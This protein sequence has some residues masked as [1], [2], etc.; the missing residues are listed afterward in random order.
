MR[1][2]RNIERIGSIIASEISKT[3][4]YEPVTVVTPLGAKKTVRLISQPVIATVLRAGL[5]LQNGLLDCF[6]HADAAFIS[7]YR[8]HDEGQE[9]EVVVEYIAVPSLQ[10]RTL[11][12]ADPMLATGKSLVLAYRAFVA[13]AGVPARTVI[14][15]VIGSAAGV[16][17]VQEHIPGADIW[18][19]ALDDLLDEN[20]YIV[21]GLGDAGDLSY[22]P[23]LP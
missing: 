21:P 1:F 13:R 22:G 17:Y 16:A 20:F 11:I 4:D 10:D 9:V 23:K 14:A 6:D 7:A 18:L 3:L 15:A 2:R 12:L 8:R 5:P 19:G